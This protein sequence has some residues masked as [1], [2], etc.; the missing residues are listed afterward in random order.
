L[1]RKAGNLCGIHNNY[2]QA[3]MKRIDRL[4][5]LLDYSSSVDNLT[6]S[7]SEK[8]VVMRALIILI[9]VWGYRS[10]AVTR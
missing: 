10:H 1:V 6:V 5:T 4:R 2:V 3:Q 9:I 7:F 8:M